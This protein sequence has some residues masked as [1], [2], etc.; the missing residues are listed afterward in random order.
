M[1]KNKYKILI[2]SILLLL[3]LLFL[4]DV[5]SSFVDKDAETDRLY[6]LCK[7]WGYEKYNN[8]AF[9]NGDKNC[10]AEFLTLVN[11]VRKAKDDDE[12]NEILYNWVVSI[13]TKQNNEAQENNTNIVNLDSPVLLTDNNWIKDT[14]FLGEKLSNAISSKSTV[15]HYNTDKSPVIFTDSNIPDFKNDIHY[16]SQNM[17]YGNNNWRLL[18]LFRVWNII[19]YYSPYAHI[20]NVDWDQ[21]LRTYIPQIML[22][23]EKTG[24]VIPQIELA[25]EYY[26]TIS[27]MLNHINDENIRF[28]GMP[29]FYFEEF[30]NYVLPVK[31]T[32]INDQY[33]V[34]DIFKKTLEIL[35]GDIIKSI[36]GNNIEDICEERKPYLHY[37]DPDNISEDALLLMLCSKNSNVKV[38][39]QRDSDII[40]LSVEAFDYSKIYEKDIAKKSKQYITDNSGFH[41]SSLYDLN[42]EKVKEIFETDDNCGVILDCRYIS[43]IDYETMS[44]YIDS[45]F[46]EGYFE[47]LPNVN[48]PGTY[49]SK[50]VNE[51]TNNFNGV[52]KDDMPIIAIVDKNTK[53]EAEKIALLIKNSENGLVVGEETLGTMGNIATIP[54]PGGYSVTFTC[55]LLGDKR[56]S[57]MKKA[58]VIPDIEVKHTIDEIK[59]GKD[60]ML[61]KAI[62]LTSTLP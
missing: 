15:R 46:A 59:Y 13:N 26:L 55:S 18:G 58:N 36:D 25:K 11:K 44:K 7:V 35:K 62:E 27:K 29:F 50:K 38:E 37:S 28:N 8:N 4:Y 3:T 14:E 43:N 53:G 52:L 41:I 48:L 57:S 49:I 32:R 30:G 31:I 19:E 21:V 5:S 10:D 51:H 20:Q 1:I 61:E 34:T 22:S 42:D 56:I 39:I 6:K 45:N 23:S 12:V 54:V 60:L 16:S 40:N 47:L 24:K 33:V 9:L 2:L 17:L